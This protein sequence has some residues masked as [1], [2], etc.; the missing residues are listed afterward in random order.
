MRYTPA[1]KKRILAEVKKYYVPGKTS[2]AKA[3][4]KAKLSVPTYYLWKN[5]KTAKPARRKSVGH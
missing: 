4:K 1:E 2:L 5:K 3:C